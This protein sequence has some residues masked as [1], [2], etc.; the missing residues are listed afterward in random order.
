MN[1][2]AI[3]DDT[4]QRLIAD[5]GRDNADDL[6]GVFLQE[7]DERARRLL[8]AAHDGDL[9]GVAREAHPLKSAAATYGALR[10][11]EALCAVESAAR[12]GR[13]E[14]A[15]ALAAELDEEIEAVR[16]MLASAA[17]G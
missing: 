16:A 11:S 4:L 12:A 9:E 17:P 13:R 2:P 8:Q 6:V 10:L 3:D 5:V 14:H 15:A 1:Q 7:L